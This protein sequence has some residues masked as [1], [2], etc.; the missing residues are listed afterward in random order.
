MRPSACAMSRIEMRNFCQNLCFT[1]H[2]LRVKRFSSS[3]KLNHA[4]RMVDRFI[5]LL[6][7]ASSIVLV[8][9]N[10]LCLCVQH[11]MANLRDNL[12][13]ANIM[14]QICDEAMRK[15]DICAK[16]WALIQQTPTNIAEKIYY[17][18]TT[19]THSL[20][21]HVYKYIKCGTHCVRSS[22]HG[23]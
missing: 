21:L 2:R 8:G 9:R 22:T 6:L 17:S 20:H 7:L 15:F 5:S 19:M 10:A 12:L 4:I 13:N 23:P 14:F 11:F 3:P 1:V 16:L 18:F